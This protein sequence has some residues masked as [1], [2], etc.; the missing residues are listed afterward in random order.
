MRAVDMIALYLSQ[1]PA[2]IQAAAALWRPC[3]HSQGPTPAAAR[4]GGRAWRHKEGAGAGNKAEEGD[5]E[6]QEGCWGAHGWLAA[7]V[8]YVWRKQ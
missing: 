6:E 3:L 2:A 1:R 4:G 5:E 7:C 8:S